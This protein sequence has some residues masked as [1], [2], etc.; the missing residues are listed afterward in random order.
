MC[1]PGGSAGCW[2]WR[3]EEEEEVVLPEL[4]VAGSPV[5]RL[6]MLRGDWDTTLQQEYGQHLLHLLNIYSVIN[7]LNIMEGGEHCSQMGEMSKLGS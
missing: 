5:C 6:R 1:P 2:G 4:R 3:G 7:I